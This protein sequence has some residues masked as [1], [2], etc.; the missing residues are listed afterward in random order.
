MVSV[1]SQ[2]FPLS[3]YLNM[4]LNIG[5]RKLETIGKAMKDM[6]KT[7]LIRRVLS[8]NEH[9][10]QLGDHRRALQ[11]AV[12][13]FQVSSSVQISLACHANR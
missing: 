8:N 7:T 12:T 11:D 13:K 6:R 3:L 4:L 2:Q 1:K 9:A 10:T 5:Y